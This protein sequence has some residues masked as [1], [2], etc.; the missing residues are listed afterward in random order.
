MVINQNELG[1]LDFLNNDRK[2]DLFKNNVVL[3]DFKE[4]NDCMDC[5]YFNET[6]FSI[7]YA[8]TNDLLF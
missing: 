4:F 1:A 6:T 5:K 2:L 7:K 3:E 8:N